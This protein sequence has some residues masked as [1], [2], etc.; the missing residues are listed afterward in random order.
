MCARV[1]WWCGGVAVV[2]CVVWVRS[3]GT[4]TTQSHTDFILYKTL[5]DKTRT[6]QA[7]ADQDN[8]TQITSR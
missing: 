8:K 6:F 4:D 5:P 1:V 2:G 7:K 3:E